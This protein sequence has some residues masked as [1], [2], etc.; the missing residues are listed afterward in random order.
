MKRFLEP[1]E[2]VKTVQH[3]G[4]SRRPPYL[5]LG[6]G[7]ILLRDEGMGVR[8]VEAMQQQ[9]LPA[10]VEVFD[11]ATFGLDLLDVVAD[12][13]TVIVIDVID[14]DVIDRDYPPGTVMRLD[15]IDLQGWRGPEISLHDVGLLDTLAVANLLECAPDNV[16]VFGVLPK[17]VEEG[18]ELSEELAAV[19]PEVVRLVRTELARAM[20][21]DAACP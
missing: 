19:V 3:E 8:V 15:L 12:R 16:V 17:I 5:V 2:A 1:W 9:G 14:I 4:S 7:N 10:E 18:L 21:R 11:G 6:I 20:A 13:R